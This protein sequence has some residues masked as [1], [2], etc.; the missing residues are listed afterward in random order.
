MN[1]AD[2]QRGE[3]CGLSDTLFGPAAASA[4]PPAADDQTDW[5]QGYRAGVAYAKKRAQAIADAG[6]VAVTPSA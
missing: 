3:R 4:K 6:A 2:Y 5:A 1:N